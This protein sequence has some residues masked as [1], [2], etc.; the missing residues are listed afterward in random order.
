[1]II[2]SDWIANG[3][4]TF[5]DLTAAFQFRGG[6]LKSSN[7]FIYCL[8]SIQGSM[9]GIKRINDIMDEKTGEC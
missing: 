7:M 6:V 3:S 8:I 2:S 4:L 5:G 1:L 9:A